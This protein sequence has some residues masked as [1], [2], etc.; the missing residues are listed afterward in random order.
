MD[1]MNAP[2]YN[3]YGL[4]MNPNGGTT[5]F[6]GSYNNPQ[7]Q[8]PNTPTIEQQKAIVNNLQTPNITTGG[9]R[10]SV[11]EESGDIVIPVDNDIILDAD[12]NGIKKERTKKVGRPPKKDDNSLIV[13]PDAEV[14]NGTIEDMPTSYS[15]METNGMLRDTMSQ[16]DALNGELMQEFT[17]IR[18][19]R[20]LRNKHNVMIGLSENIGT[21]IGNKI[22]VIREI[23][24]TIS[25]SNEMDYKKDKDRRAAATGMDDDKYIADLYK[26]FM[27]NGNVP[28]APQL[29]ALDSSLYGSAGIV[30]ADLRN[31]DPSAGIVDAGYLNY[32]S[33][34]SSEQNVMRYEN[35]PNVKQV[36]VYDASTGNKFF[37]V[38]DTSTGNVVPNVPVYDQMF[39]E[40]TTIDI[41]NR[42]AKNINLNE[43]FPLIIINEG[44]TSEY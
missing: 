26:S 4:P 40:D 22:S 10:F 27:V 39:M 42:I 15:Y 12:G 21:L 1:F 5:N 13:R 38:V 30:R 18:H 28:T 24:S 33:N 6:S 11:K 19:N 36:V 9:F 14:V 44:V 34:L 17:S 37:Q 2:M 7:Q 41:K 35:N 3:T 8:I 23:N 43:T 20:T 32:L 16:I 29:P 25:K 31:Q